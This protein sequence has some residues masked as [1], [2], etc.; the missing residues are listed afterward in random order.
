MISVII[1]C[2]NEEEHV[3]RC[4]RSILSCG[5]KTGE[6]EI[7]VVD[8]GSSDTSPEIIATFESV[9]VVTIHRNTAATARN[10]GRAH[11]VGDLLCFLDA[12]TSVNQTWRQTVEGLA[13]RADS[14]FA[15]FSCRVPAEPSFVERNWFAPLYRKPRY[16]A[17]ANIC[18]SATLFDQ[19][20]GFDA[21]LVT[22]EDVDLFQ[23]AVDSGVEP[24]FEP[25]L[26]VVHHG[27]PSSIAAFF[28]REAWHGVSDM[29]SLAA[30]VTSK[31]A[32]VSF[33]FS[34]AVATAVISTLIGAFSIAIFAAAAAAGLCV[35]F[36][37]YKFGRRAKPTDI[38]STGAKLAM[39]A[40]YMLARTWSLTRAITGRTAR[41]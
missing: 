4:L 9:K 12:D 41:R 40:V 13:A 25:T 15:G 8:N 1:P 10:T 23:R 14:V 22:A 35:L 18:I 11:A 26:E 36:V 19:L 32:V 38:R 3:E 17:G 7:I 5:F 28:R 30:F 31:V 34:A 33:L 39:A 20:G 37:V 16:F 24:E 6:F 2:F 21:N 29:R 27:Y